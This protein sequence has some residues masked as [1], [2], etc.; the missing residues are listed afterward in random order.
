MVAT[1]ISSPA[2]PFS[3]TSTSAVPSSDAGTVRHVRCSQVS[4]STAKLTTWLAACRPESAV[5][6][7]DAV[8]PN[9]GEWDSSVIV[10]APDLT[11]NRY[12][13]VSDQ[14]NARSRLRTDRV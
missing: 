6:L 2:E 11:T 8:A 4:C 5:S 1:S 7:N 14:L 9:C 12:T 13:A 3:G 10:G